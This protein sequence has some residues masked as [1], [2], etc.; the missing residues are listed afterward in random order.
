MTQDWSILFVFGFDSSGNFKIQIPSWP[1]PPSFSAPLPLLFVSSFI[2]KKVLIKPEFGE[3]VK[4]SLHISVVTLDAAVSDSSPSLSPV[5]G[6]VEGALRA[7]LAQRRRGGGSAVNSE[8]SQQQLKP[9][10]SPRLSDWLTCRKAA[11]GTRIW[12]LQVQ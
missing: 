11:A 9:E 6:L 7:E 8:I 10:V 4:G 12:P 3:C 2:K 5:S 1:S